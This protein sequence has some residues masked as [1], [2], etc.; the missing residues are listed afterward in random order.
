MFMSMAG[1]LPPK[2]P[3][4]NIAVRKSIACMKSRYRVIGKKTAMAIEICNPG[5]APNTRPIRIPGTTT[6]QG[7]ALENSMSIA[8]ASASKLIT[9]AHPQDSCR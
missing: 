9:T 8:P 7:V 5:M 2:L 4:V 3:P 1:M 6:S